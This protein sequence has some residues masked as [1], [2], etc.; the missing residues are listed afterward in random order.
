MRI[1]TFQTQKAFENAAKIGFFRGDPSEIL[2]YW[3]DS[4]DP[5]FKGAYEF[6]I[7]EM[8]KRMPYVGPY[9]IWAWAERPDLR[10]E[11]HTFH[12]KTL[13]ITAEVPDERILLSD[14]EMYHACLDN[15]YLSWTEKED[16]CMTAL[17]EMEPSAE[18]KRESWKK[19][20]DIKKKRTADEARWLGK[21]TIVQC[22]IDG[23]SMKEIVKIT[24]FK[25]GTPRNLRKRVV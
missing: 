23:I 17:G 10:K 11:R 20:F 13:L 25:P 7:E 3:D 12:D 2:K 8:K 22:C 5:M 1:Y 18:E 24:H 16:D 4:W 6:I 19:M 15:S 9:P 14:F 21:E